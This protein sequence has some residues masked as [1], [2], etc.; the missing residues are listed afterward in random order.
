MILSW[1]TWKPPG[2][3][4]F[5][6]R[7]SALGGLMTEPQKIDP[8]F[9]TPDVEEIVRKTKRTDE[10]KAL[11]ASLKE[12]SL[13]QGAKT[14]V[15]MLVRE[16]IFGFDNEVSSKEM[17]KGIEVE[18]EAI[19]VVARVYGLQLAKNTE[20]RTNHGITG[21]CDICAP[22]GRDIK[23]PWSLGSFPICEED[24]T[25]SAYY[26]QA[27][28]YMLLWDQD[29]WSID[30][31]MMPT[32]ERLIRYEPRQLHE[33][34]HLPEYMRVTTW[35]VHRD[36]DAIRLIRLKVEAA[37]KYAKEV[38]EEFDRTHRALECASLS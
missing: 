2:M 13:S 3:L 15:R 31:V 28:G 20:R 16:W 5:N 36:M 9:C 29:E 38:M 26:W 1:Q 21:E 34:G 32:P 6:I 12:K 11:I 35:T 10:E 27:Q 25:D 4:D 30:Y 22:T 7:C 8:S 33:V 23:C 18:E 24:A 19:Q 17:E 37:R 14:Q